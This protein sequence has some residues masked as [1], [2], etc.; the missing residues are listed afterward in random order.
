LGLGDEVARELL[1]V[2]LR[3][4]IFAACEHVEERESVLSEL[5]RG[6]E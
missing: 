6:G 5:E 3:R 1:R 2:D 4:R